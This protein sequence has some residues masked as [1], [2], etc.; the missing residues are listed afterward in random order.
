MTP[1]GCG[2]IAPRILAQ[3]RAPLDRTFPLK[4][5]PDAIRFAIL[6]RSLTDHFPDGYPTAPPRK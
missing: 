5:S 4:E 6:K 2:A 1:T 3:L